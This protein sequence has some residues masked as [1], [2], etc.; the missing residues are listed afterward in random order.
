VDEELHRVVAAA[1]RR[2]GQRYTPARR[3]LIEAIAGAP[4]PV[5]TAELVAVRP[6]LPQSTTYRNLAVLEQAGVLHRVHG[7]D[8]C[9]RF[10]LSEELAGHHHH[11]VCTSC[12]LVEDFT[13]PA[14]FERS[15]STVIGSV[16][17]VAGFHPQAHRLDVLGTCNACTP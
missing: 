13:A 4:R 7:S 16:V 14:R 5:T 2:L 17:K 8:D 3:A 6:G 9:A 10:E 15:L 11:L 12:G 1:L